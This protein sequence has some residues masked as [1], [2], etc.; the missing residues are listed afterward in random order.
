MPILAPLADVIFSFLDF[1]KVIFW[2]PF[3]HKAVSKINRRSWAGRSGA[4]FGASWRRK[5]D[6][7][8]F[9]TDLGP[10]RDRLFRILDELSVNC[11]SSLG[12][13][14]S[15]HSVAKPTMHLNKTLAQRNARKHSASPSGDVRVGSQ[16]RSSNLQF[17]TMPISQ[18]V[19]SL[20][21]PLWQHRA[22]QQ[23][24]KKISFEG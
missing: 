16:F 4:V 6:C 14:L 9:S 22:F 2:I 10:I 20:S 19:F 24:D 7:Y 5:Q 12:S 3:S 18:E 15:L 23:A 1:R 13:S 8:R 17:K 21:S 11:R